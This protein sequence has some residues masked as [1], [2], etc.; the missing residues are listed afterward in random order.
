MTLHV[1]AVAAAALLAAS[2]PSRAQLLFHASFDG[3]SPVA[4][5]AAGSPAPVVATAL[6]WADGVSGRA[7]RL[8]RGGKSALAYAV[9]G[10]LRRESG[11]VSLWFR[12]E[13][14][15]ADSQQ[16]P[17]GDGTMRYLLSNPQ[18]AGRA[19]SGAV[20]LR[21]HREMLRGD[22]SDDADSYGQFPASGALDGEWHHI[23]MAWDGRGM[24]LYLD[25][26]HH[27]TR[28][29]SYSPMRA[30]ISGGFRF[31]RIVAFDRF[32]VGNLDGAEQCGGDIDELR[33]FGNPLG[34]DEIA[35]LAAE[36]QPSG[37]R[38]SGA[39]SPD[40]MALYARN[41][42]NPYV[43]ACPEIPGVIPAED[44]ELIDEIRLDSPESVERLR[45]ENRL[46]TVGGIS[47]G[48]VGG[49]P[50]AELG[51]ERG[52]RLALRFA[53]VDDASP[54][55]AFDLDYPDDKMRTIDVTIQG[56][57]DPANDYTMQCGV[58][59][60]GEYPSSG[61]IATH[62]TV[63]WRRPGDIAFVVMSA[64]KRG[65]PAAVSA[66]R[67]WRVKSGTLPPAVATPAAASARRSGSS[68]DDSPARHGCAPRRHVGLYFEDPA[69]GWDFSVPGGIS[70][71]E[72]MGETIDRAIATM[73]FAGEDLLLY[74]GAWYQGLIGESYD[75]R[76]HAPDFLSGWYV[77]FDA[78][79]DLGVVPTLNVNNMPVP[80]G[81]VTLESMTNG[82][83]HSSPVAIHDTGL[84]NWGGWHG[85]PPNFNVAHPEV[86][87]YVL[88]MVDALVAQGAPHPSFKGLCLHVTRHALL[89]WGG[90]ESGY[91]DY[92]IDA[93]R[94][95]TGIRVPADR[96]DPLRGKASANWLKAH[97]AE[98]EAWLDWRCDV[99]ARLYGEIARRLLAARPDLKLWINCCTATYNGQ[100]FSPDPDFVA[101]ANRAAGIDPARLEAAAPNLVLSQCVVP[102]DWRCRGHLL[103]DPA[104]KEALR[105]LCDSPE[106]YVLPKEAT[107]PW[108]HQHDRYWESAIGNPARNGGRETLTCD[109]MTETGW[110]V[111]TINPSGASAIRAFVLPLRYDDVLGV[112][113]GGFLIGTYGT[114]PFIARF[115]RAFRALPAV[116]MD[117]FFRQGNVVARKAVVDG[118]TWGYVVN[119]DF[120]VA[121]VGVA[122]P[123][124]TVD[125]V[126][127][128]S[129]QGAL[130]LGPYEMIPFVAD[131]ENGAMSR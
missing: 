105:R 68:A 96:A 50:Y 51:E 131:S 43:G 125:A 65:A 78:E 67:I 26:R 54:I 27:C 53:A 117:E 28:N 84:P 35:A 56:A 71:P 4:T 29:A 74:P 20:I 45:A 90:I 80:D 36:F 46:R 66:V 94:D 19:G 72:S 15:M 126:T 9:D 6:E 100:T 128:V 116:R 110:R 108:V 109:W 127:G 113:K 91:N 24:R 34:D 88:G 81:L 12:R 95:A 119:T 52:S 62:R 98:M 42:A 60:G 115:A 55:Y 49:I 89:S 93:F 82:T 92:C 40:Y 14:D 69:I 73:R 104:R 64:Q 58:L 31:S 30:A 130:R 106:T 18:P 118:R 122:L 121:E 48:E 41:G 86:Q 10:N 44:L 11:T 101:R 22:V 102:A 99:L 59:A 77:K 37:R 123:A 120:A 1:P 103:P 97:P 2:P 75:P 17:S 33:V 47:F 129:L 124:G 83:L 114:E 32:F 25:G 79:G 70:T 16:P 111:T 61:G 7:A 13:G 85:T 76:S 112:S 8:S 3:N 39:T 107:R 21:L 38:A 5:M 23:A 63:W 87:S 57:Q